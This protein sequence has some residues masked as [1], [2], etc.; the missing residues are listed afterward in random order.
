MPG[1]PVCKLWSTTAPR[2]RGSSST[3][4]A[5]ESS[6]SGIRPTESSSVSHGTTRSVPGMGARCSSTWLTSTAS[7]RSCPITRVTVVDRCS[8]MPKSSR[9]FFTLRRRPLAYG[10]SSYT[11]STETPSS[12]QRRAMISPMSPEPKMTAREPGL[13]FSILMYRCARPAVNTP[14]G[15]LPGILI[16]LRVRSRQPMARTTARPMSCN[17]PVGLMSVTVWT[18]A[19]SVD[20]PESSPITMLFK[21]SAMSVSCTWSIKRCAYSGPVSSCL[22]CERPKP[23]WMHWR[24]IPP[25]CRSRSTM[26]TRASA[27]CAASAAAI[28]AGPPPM[29]TTSKAC[30]C[31]ASVAPV[32][33]HPSRISNVAILAHPLQRSLNQPGSGIL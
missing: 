5:T 4:A 27:L 25:R 1:T 32:S 30:V 18:V 24:R 12:V 17:M 20:S 8:G 10:M 9:Q 33:A 22:K 21:N 19:S 2:V 29:T 28:P 15:R 23:G 7:T 16:S 11:P 3:P 14:A 31:T 13:R 26:A 6:F